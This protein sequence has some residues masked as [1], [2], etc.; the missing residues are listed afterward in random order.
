ME[1]I[2]KFTKGELRDSIGESLRQIYFDIEDKKI[3]TL[4]Q[5]KERID[6]LEHWV[7]GIRYWD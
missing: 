1:D 3:I 7:E 6:K 2:R 4:N 5:V